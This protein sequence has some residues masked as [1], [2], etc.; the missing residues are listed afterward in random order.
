MTR[1]RIVRGILCVAAALGAAAAPAR[2]EDGPAPPAET[3]APKASEAAAAAIAAH[4][5]GDAKTL[6]EISARPNPDVWAVVDHLLDRGER[7][8]ALALAKASPGPDTERL[9]DYVESWK[10]CAEDA[11]RRAALKQSSALESAKR[12]VE[13]LGVL[14]GVSPGPEDVLRV[15]ILQTRASANLRLGRHA[16]AVAAYEA[17]VAVAERIGWIARAAQLLYNGGTGALRAGDRKTALRLLERSASLHERRGDF[18][19]HS[20]ALLNV[21]NAKWMDAHREGARS[22]AE[23]A[24]ETAEKSGDEETVL[25]ALA[26]LAAFLEDRV[27]ARALAER[28]IP[29]AERRNARDVLGSLHFNLGIQTEYVAGPAAALPHFAKSLEIRRALGDRASVAK[30]LRFLG[31]TRLNLGDREEGLADLD[32]ARAIAESLGLEEE[33]GYV[34]LAVGKSWHGRGELGKAAAHYG[35]AQKHAERAG[36]PILGA[37]VRLQL[38]QAD[39]DRGDWAKARDALLEVSREFRGWKLRGEEADALSNLATAL[40]NLGDFRG[41]LPHA[42][43]ALRLAEEDGALPNRSNAL[44]ALARIRGE[45]GDRERSLAA[46]GLALEWAAKSGNRGFEAAVLLHIADV[47]ERRHDPVQAVRCAERARALSEA[48]WSKGSLAVAHRKLGLLRYR[49]SDF[50]GAQTSHEAALALDEAAGRSLET[51]WDL[52][53]LANVLLDRGASARAQQCLERALALFEK[54]GAKRDHATALGNLQIV[55]EMVGRSAGSLATHRRIVRLLEECGDDRALATGLVKLADDLLEAGA[56]A[57]A[58]AEARRALALFEKCDDRDGRAFARRCLGTVH[59]ARGEPGAAI[60]EFRD[61]L[62]T[63]EELESVSW[64]CEA[65]NAIARVQAAQDDFPAALATWRR[66]ADDA[67][68]IGEPERERN[69]L[70]SIASCLLAMERPREA[71]AAARRSIEVGGRVVSG[72]ADEHAAGARASFLPA[73][74]TGF[75]AAQTLGDAAEALFFLESARAGALLEGVGSGSALREAVLSPELLEEER[76]ARS[77]ES[78]AA[79]SLGRARASGDA[80]LFE[81]ASAALAAAREARAAVA[82]RIQREAKLA[83]GVVEPRIAALAE[84]QAALRPDEAFVAYALLD[85]HAVALVVR[86]QEAR[87]VALGDAEELRAAV[88]ARFDDAARDPSGAA[89]RLRAAAVEPLRLAAVVKRVLVSTDDVLSFAPFCALLADRE[90]V[91]VPSATTW[92]LLREAAAAKGEGVL[93]LGD[94]DYAPK[95]PVAEP[96]AL[97]RSAERLVP[98]PGTREEAMAV[99]TKVLL[100]ADATEGALRAALAGRRWRA[101]HLACHG[102]IDTERP[103]LSS[104]ALT[105]TVE[106]DGFLTA[107]EVFRLR[108]S[109]DLVALSACRTGGGKVVRGEGVLGL[110]RAFMFAGAPRVLVSL[111]KVDDAATAALMKEFYSRWNAG[112]PA[113]RALREAQAHVAS[114]P[115]WR[116]PRFWAAWALWGLPE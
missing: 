44:L 43:E 106:D 78:E 57:E 80:K 17:A 64:S 116:H 88:A 47:H 71:V 28:A 100:G 66:V 45:L 10:P 49:A 53:N 70:A 15:R 3:R 83:A 68:R 12:D 115:P 98:L 7:G 67:A 59:E 5:A 11:P 25:R 61:A 104:L 1:S 101:V 77:S 89:E 90:V 92:L 9:P 84:V 58:E 8:V 96:V 33:L 21:A 35:E 87:I 23:R 50:A 18:G 13:V 95:V 79:W 51:G 94:P 86:P 99:G 42:E 2:G 85:P 69:A 29:I 20:R 41:A 4:A 72:F 54:E 73:V 6:A 63:W 62:A 97:V 39:G 75:H 46:L 111:W 22:D 103:Y 91:H 48:V 60:G 55:E 82:G 16:D 65:R 34:E 108:V 52:V 56:I 14:D 38:A 31:E 107:L 30:T 109:A 112:L 105:P 37:R 19:A 24:L 81:E 74:A 114:Q 110:T 36:A 102:L 27:R 113:A 40:S 26:S 76:A 32:E 93:A